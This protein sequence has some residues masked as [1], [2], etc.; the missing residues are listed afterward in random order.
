VNVVDLF[1]GNRI[2]AR[3][4]LV[5]DARYLDAILSYIAQLSVT[6]CIITAAP[7]MIDP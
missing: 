1:G 7:V 6:L 3:K 2:H 4:A 5:R